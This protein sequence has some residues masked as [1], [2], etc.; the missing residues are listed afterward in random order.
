MSARSSDQIS[1]AVPFEPIRRAATRRPGAALDR[2]LEPV[3]GE[4]FRVNC[5]SATL[6]ARGVADATSE[7]RRCLARF[8]CTQSWPGIVIHVQAP[9]PL[10]QTGLTDRIHRPSEGEPASMDS[11]YL[12]NVVLVFDDVMARRRAEQAFARV[13]WDSQVPTRSTEGRFF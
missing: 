11:E 6:P 4:S 2:R 5:S 13:Q 3:P 1:P 7:R 10:E 12:L 8:A 9:K